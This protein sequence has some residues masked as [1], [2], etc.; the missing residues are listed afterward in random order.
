M[1]NGLNKKIKTMENRK[2]LLKDYLHAVKN[3]TVRDFME[4]CIETIPEYWF[5]APAS[6]SGHFHPNYA[7]GEGGLMRHTLGILHFAKRLLE[8]D[9]YRNKFTEKE[10]DLIYVACLMHDSRKCGSDEDYKESKRTRFDHPLLAADAIRSMTAYS[11][12]AEEKEIVASAVEAHMGQWNTKGEI[13]LPIPQT[14]IQK[15]VH[16]VDYL[17]SMKECEIAFNNDLK[18]Y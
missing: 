16:L 11:I 12:T 2:E 7:H 4:K 3:N 1:K 14:N 10:M 18:E 17:A 15:F 6:S 5:K 9:M 13:T 8:N